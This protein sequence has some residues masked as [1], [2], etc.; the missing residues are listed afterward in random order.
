M[1]EDTPNHEEGR[2]TPRIFSCEWMA[3]TTHLYKVQLSPTLKR[4]VIIGRIIIIISRCCCKEGE[5]EE[6]AIG[7]NH[8]DDHLLNP[9]P[10]TLN[11]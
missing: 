6:K 5:E 4:I 11:F 8:N 2:V 9:A 7:P 1:V 10:N 3:C